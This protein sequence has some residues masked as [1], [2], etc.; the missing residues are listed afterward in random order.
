MARSEAKDGCGV[1]Y[2]FAGALTSISLQTWRYD[3]CKTR[4]TLPQPVS[5]PKIIRKNSRS[6]SVSLRHSTDAPSEIGFDVFDQ[7]KILC[8]QSLLP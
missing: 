8:A 4:S 5:D 7:E 2:F 1:D 6:L 3:G